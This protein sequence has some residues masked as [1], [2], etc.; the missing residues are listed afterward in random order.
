[1]APVASL[2]ALWLIVSVALFVLLEVF[3][4]FHQRIRHRPNRLFVEYLKYPGEVI[5]MLWKGSADICRRPAVD[6]AA[7]CL[8]A[9]LTGPWLD[10]PRTWS[11][12]RFWLTWPV[13][14]ARLRSS[15][16]FQRRPSSGQSGE[17]RADQ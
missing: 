1:M 13:G 4:G 16:P 2:S 15:D 6:R 5:P 10:Q 12:A 3:T 11:N 17:L 7:C 9:R 8:L 14:G